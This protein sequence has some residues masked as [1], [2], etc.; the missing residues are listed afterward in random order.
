MASSPSTSAGDVCCMCGDRGLPEEL[1]RCRLCRVRLQHR[2]CSDLYPRAT[3]YRRC[4]WCL[5]ERVHGDGHGHAA[6]DKST[7]R[8]KAISSSPSAASS[9]DQET[10]TS[11]EAERQQRLQE[12]TGCSASR[13][14]P[15]TGPGRPVK[16]QKTAAD[17]GEAPGAR[18]AAKG[19]NG[20][21]RVTQ[22]GKKTGVKVRVRR[23]KLLAEVI[24]C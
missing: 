20:N 11:G 23:Y 18:A 21:K 4:N 13:R 19:N 22:A 12:A 14:P 2:Y 1:F 8:R 24:S 17:E 5:R 15:D 16:K 9:S 10:S 6:A 7:V 3:A